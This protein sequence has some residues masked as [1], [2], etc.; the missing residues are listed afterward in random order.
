MNL[1]KKI[2]AVCSFCTLLTTA[3]CF[4]TTNDFVISE[5]TNYCYKNYQ[6]MEE[7]ENVFWNMLDKEI[8]L[9]KQKYK[10]V[11]FE[12]TGGNE[13]HII[14]I[15]TSKTILSKTKNKDDIIKQLGETIKYEKDG[16][17]GEYTID[18]NSLKITTNENGFRE[19][20]IEKTITYINLDKNDLS[21]IPK[22]T[23]KDGKTLDLLNVE[24]K[25][26]STKEIG[27]YTVPN[28]YI[29][30][31]YYACKE[32]IDYPNTY[33][34]TAKYFGTATKVE[35]KPVNIT[36]KYEKIEEDNNILLPVMGTVGSFIVVVILF[37][38]GNITVYNFKNNKWKK[39]GKVKLK[40]GNTIKLNR[41]S[42]IE[43]TNKYRLVFS[44]RATQKVKGKLLTI[45]K[46][47]TTKQMLANV[48]NEKHYSIEVRI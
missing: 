25:V 21:Y 13:E 1:I 45:K 33:T 31:A 28:T 29:G 38:T 8:E 42:I 7:E 16:F 43:D 6:L 11:S 4:A 39:V 9:D 2:I 10:Y 15:S 46:N 20:L 30:K 26:E 48:N 47:S 22:Q 44:K 5:D 40:K 19:V 37:F 32:R 27:G 12:K 23:Q 3:N 18:P 24:W 35:E 17:M 14:D 41:F 34:V 36:V